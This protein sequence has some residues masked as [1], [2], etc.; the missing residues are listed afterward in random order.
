MYGFSP[1]I[2]KDYKFVSQCWV[3]PIFL[4]GCVFCVLFLSVFFSVGHQGA[5]HG[6]LQAMIESLRAKSRQRQHQ[7]SKLQAE[8]QL[9]KREAVLQKTVQKDTQRYQ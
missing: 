2:S 1:K 4:Y 8:E 6:E 9:L 5:S 3:K 7:L